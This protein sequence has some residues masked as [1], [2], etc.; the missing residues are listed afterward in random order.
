MSSRH[1]PTKP[2]VPHK[3]L[4]DQRSA[5]NPRGGAVV[6]A[7]AGSG[8][9]KVLVDRVLRLL[10]S[11]ASPSRILC[12]TFTKAAAATMTNRVF[13][14]LARWVT[15]DPAKL[16]QVL[17]MLS[18]TRPSGAMLV[19]ARRLFARAIET[20]GGLKIETI[21][22]FC[23]R[24][25]HLFP[26]EANVPARFNVLDD[27]SEATLMATAR[28]NVLLRAG[29]GRDL[30]LSAALTHL[31]REVT[32]DAIDAAIEA[33]IATGGLL[34][35]T[36]L[37]DMRN[38][39]LD[40]AGR[41]MGL[42]AHEDQASITADILD[43]G[44]LADD[45]RSIVDGLRASVNVKTDGALADQLMAASLARNA[46]RLAL[47]S[48]VFLTDRGEPRSDRFVTTKAPQDI[49]DTLRAERDRIVPL[50]DKLRAASAIVR[51]CN[52][53]I[54]ADAMMAEVTRAKRERALL[55]FDDLINRTASLLARADA[56]W[57]LY[58]LD[59]GIEHLLVDEAQ[60]N[61]PTQWNILDRLVA[62]FTTGQSTHEHGPVRTMFAVGDPK[63]SIYGFQGAA[64]GRFG[65]VLRSWE[66]RA[67]IVNLP[68][69]R[70][71][72]TLSFRSAATILAG[73]DAVFAQPKTARGLTFASDEMP[74]PHQS[75]WPDM[76]GRIDVWEL[77]RPIERTTPDAWSRPVDE[78]DARAPA[79]VVAERVAQRV[80]RLIAGDDANAPVPPGEILI[81]ARKR[82]VAFEATL[83][84][85]KDAGVPV[86]GADRIE[87]A[88]HIAVQDV[89]AIARA[90]LLPLDDLTLA[91]ALLTPIGGLD[92]D[93]LMT[94][95]AERGDNVS[96]MAALDLAANAGN[97]QAIA[98][99]NLLATWRGM[100]KQL[101]PFRFMTNLLGPMGGR[102]ALVSRLGAEAGDAIDAL[103][104]RVLNFERQQAP[105]LAA[106]LAAFGTTSETKKRD[107][108]A[109]ARDVRVMTVHGAKGLEAQVVILLDGSEPAAGSKSRHVMVPIPVTGQEPVPIWFPRKDDEPVC[110]HEPR[111]QEKDAATAEHN[112]LLY[113]AMTRAKQHL[114]I[115][116]FIGLKPKDPP[117]DC[118]H[119]MISTG[120]AASSLPSFEAHD[121]S[122]FGLTSWGERNMGMGE[123]LSHASIMADVVRP[124]W[125]DS[126][127]THEP[128]ALP[129][130][131]PSS[132]GV[133]ADR[134]PRPNDGP[135]AADRRLAGT[136]VHAL[137]E[138]L[139]DIAPDRREATAK[140]YLL[141]RGARLPDAM[142]QKLVQDALA[143]LSHPDLV[144]LFGSTSRAE[145]TV[146]GTIAFGPDAT[147]TAVSGQID[148]MAV[149]PEAIYLMDIKTTARAPTRWQDAAAS[150]VVQLAI[151]SA[152][153][154]Q[155]F[156]DRPVKA[157]LVYTAGPVVI[158]VPTEALNEAIAMK[159]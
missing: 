158:S 132:A 142:R 39:V 38:H 101:G 53:L 20:P 35:R 135:F 85:L 31:A 7:N 69:E 83:K 147:A 149:L 88:N 126:P 4:A 32:D 128:E 113:V 144:P 84:A 44:L 130:L 3:T 56:A 112:R 59:A 43:N 57:V 93:G 115:A 140:A 6:A 145:V 117:E 133:A 109:Q 10:L 137:I 125:L 97:S 99:R 14:E 91:T 153:L 105:S 148:R 71:E 55:S 103:V 22:A 131:R 100:A 156:P 19:Q 37:P 107:L 80:A 67:N 81:L 120:M 12:L 63:Q 106:F 124:Q 15:L 73:V 61:N 159:A 114:I 70:V 123:A 30:A 9:T 87:L 41:A 36:A 52:L 95:A 86:A 154:G 79:V 48:A 18:G 150:H 1:D 46:E 146:A 116:P 27:A 98:A 25:L 94:I 118:W 72:L 119:M 96:L 50:I 16:S 26:F 134:S 11:G 111:E 64:P 75:A 102:H 76:P 139:P 13:N 129:P 74:P 89:I 62:E 110:T 2:V 65:E 5:A 23:E 8:K 138:R 21:H 108:E 157:L 152:L 28:G 54:L 33:A 82:G 141:A 77:V 45:L 47:Y 78:P 155:L 90:A 136:L 66:R 58:K 92:Q 49:A 127:V 60:D 104:A 151:Y 34:H 17:E 121:A 42:G 40:L 143:I 68:F 29:S 122:G 24:V 51:T